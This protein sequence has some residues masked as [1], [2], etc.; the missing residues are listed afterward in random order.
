MGYIAEDKKA[1]IV[2]CPVDFSTKSIVIKRKARF[3]NE[4]QKGQGDK[5]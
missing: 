3:K 2:L 1:K 5:R 4:G